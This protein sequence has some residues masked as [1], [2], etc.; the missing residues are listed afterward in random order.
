L[1]VPERR[2]N[3]AN[4]YLYAFKTITMKKIL[5][6]SVLL[7]TSLLAD[8]QECK[9]YL[10]PDIEDNFVT[11]G[12]TFSKP[13]IFSQPTVIDSRTASFRVMDGNRFYF[14]LTTGNSKDL[15]F[16][17]DVIVTFAD[18]TDLAL[19]IEQMHRIKE[20]T[21]TVTHANCRI[22]TK[23]DVSLFYYQRVTSINLVGIRQVFDLTEK[24]Q[25]KL[26]HGAICVIERVTLGSMNFDSKRTTR[27]LPD[28]GGVSFDAGSSSMIITSGTV[29]CE[30]EK[31]TIEASGAVKIS[32]PKDIVTSPYPLT[33]QIESG[34]GK[35]TLKLTYS[36]DLGCINSDSYIIFKFK[37]GSTKQVSH[38]G[39]DDCAETP[40]FL[41]DVTTIK[42]L[43]WANEVS[44]V[45]LS[46]SEYFTDLGV[47]HS[48]YLGNVLR[49][50][51]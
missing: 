10:D 31:D 13:V 30:L 32:K 50:C 35:V 41:V 19:R 36:K 26:K 42:D 27:L 9:K 34:G 23:E 24:D 14:H 44:M 17:S 43:F 33:A 6:L 16:G 15:I 1:A 7:G 51:M 40:T 47:S 29:K 28:P 48:A 18:G 3:Q 8:A 12:V 37:D 39:A 20:G 25:E 4:G 46:Y 2:T 45:R 11:E 21:E 5:L 49:Y 38:S 22:Y